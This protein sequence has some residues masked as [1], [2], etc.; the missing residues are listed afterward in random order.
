MA[1]NSANE[2]KIIAVIGGVIA[3]GFIL[4]KV[5]EN[6][7]AGLQNT[8]TGVGKGVASMGEGAG[9][10]FASAGIGISNLGTGTGKGIEYLG[11]GIGGGVDQLG[12]GVG[13]GFYQVGLGTNNLLTGGGNALTG[14]GNF[15]T[16]TGYGVNDF[17]AGAGYAASGL[18]PNDLLRTTLTL[19]GVTTGEK[20]G[21]SS[22]YSPEQRMTDIQNM[23]KNGNIIYSHPITANSTGNSESISN[24]KS[25]SNFKSQLFETSNPQNSTSPIQTSNQTSSNGGS[26]N[27]VLDTGVGSTITNLAKVVSAPTQTAGSASFMGMSVSPQVSQQVAQIVKST[28]APK[29]SFFNSAVNFV[30]GV[31]H[32][33]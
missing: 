15:A 10:G 16:S 27:H 31:T 9:E 12:A 21:G 2:L 5:A 11:Q 23:I 24:S 28:P 20:L 13:G 17:L 8:L 19:G 30:L 6:I 18:N 29:P 26:S 4:Y 1:N 7:S 3:G 25:T 32:I 14:L 33:F 22:Y